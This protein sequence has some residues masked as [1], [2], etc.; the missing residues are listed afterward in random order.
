MVVLLFP[1]FCGFLRQR[2]GSI[3]RL[4]QLKLFSVASIGLL[5]RCEG[6]GGGGFLLGAHIPE[7][8]EEGDWRLAGGGAG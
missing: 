2:K 8:Q 1:S 5:S 6:G 7:G 3:R 4:P